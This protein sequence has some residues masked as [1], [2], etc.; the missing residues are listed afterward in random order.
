M[1]GKIISITLM[2]KMHLNLT[3]T[4]QS[5]SLGK[6]DSCMGVAHGV[7]YVCMYV[8]LFVCLLVCMHT[9]VC[10]CVVC[11]CAYAWRGSRQENGGSLFN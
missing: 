4:I 7:M 2:L 5:E 11:M 6:D 9:Y 3:F 8:C 10:V 1:A